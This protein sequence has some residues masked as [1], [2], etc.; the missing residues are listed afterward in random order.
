M[1][2]SLYEF[3]V[4]RRKPTS[5]TDQIGW[6]KAQETQLSKLEIWTVYAAGREF[7]RGQRARADLERPQY[8]GERDAIVWTTEDFPSH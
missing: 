1:M 4:W 6:G 5:F 8:K 2:K 7:W 3:E